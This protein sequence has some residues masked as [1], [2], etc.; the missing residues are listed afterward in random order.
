MA[1]TT[2]HCSY[3]LLFKKVPEL[4]PFLVAEFCLP[5]HPEALGLVH[6]TGLAPGDSEAVAWAGRTHSCTHPSDLSSV[7]ASIK[8]KSAS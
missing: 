2:L 5:W 8:A 1:L 6:Q 3:A 7:L 4:C